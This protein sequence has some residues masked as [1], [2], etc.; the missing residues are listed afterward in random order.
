[1]KRIVVVGAS[2]AGMSIVRTLRGD[3]FTGELI[4]VG[5]ERHRPYDRPPLSKEILSGVKQDTDLDLPVADDLAITW[6]LGEKATSLDIDAQQV[7]VGDEPLSYDGL[8]IATGVRPRPLPGFTMDQ[9]TCHQLRT[10]DDAIALRAALRPGVRLLI[11][12]AGFIGVEVASSA[13]GLGCEVTMVSL[14]PPLAIAG[15]DV[16]GVCDNLLDELGVRRLIG[17]TIVENRPG[18]A[19]LDDGSTVDYDV[20]LVAIGSLPNVEWLSGSGLDLSDGVLCDETCAVLV[21]G[22]PIDTVVAAGDVARWPH[23][24]FSDRLLRIEHWSNAVEQGVAAARRLLHGPQ[25]A[26]AYVAVPSFWSDHCGRRLQAVGLPW[27]G[28]RRELIEG[29]HA[30]MRF[31]SASYLGDRLVGGLTYGVPKAMVQLRRQLLA[32]PA[33]Q[34][35]GA[36]R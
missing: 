31:A 22:Q 14:D 6:R 21:D 13:T 16:S 26:A 10:I 35:E 30:E 15:E 27:A 7:V 23:G 28:D 25:A 3:G 36:G 4:V 9:E 8:A 5:E 11:V 34:A 20:A 12:G 32:Q 29:L 18:A 24:M 33:P 17:R 19:R 1:M 2:L